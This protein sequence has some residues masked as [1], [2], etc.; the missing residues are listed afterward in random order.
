V[1]ER[2]VLPAEVREEYG[3]GGWMEGLMEVHRPS[4]CPKRYQQAERGLAF[5]VRAA[6]VAARLTCILQLQFKSGWGQLSEAC[7]GP[8]LGCGQ[9]W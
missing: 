3:L 1:S 5:R 7:C 4:G 6:W 9:L 8:R 2:D